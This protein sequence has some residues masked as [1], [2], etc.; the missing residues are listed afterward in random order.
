MQLNPSHLESCWAGRGSSCQS[1]QLLQFKVSNSNIAYYIARKRNPSC[2][3][4]GCLSSCNTL[5]QG[6]VPT[7]C[8]RSVSGAH[9]STPPRV[10]CKRHNIR[11]GRKGGVACN[12][13]SMDAEL[14][15][16]SSG[17]S[18]VALLE[19]RD[20]ASS[21]PPRVSDLLARLDRSGMSAATLL[22]EAE[23]LSTKVQHL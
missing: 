23:L 16:F 12:G 10:L 4:T 22:A 11:H 20:P 19:N 1:L 2:M 8:T 7:A 14:G 6:C 17:N 9:S 21:L 13:A 18:G 3:H 5:P 15:T